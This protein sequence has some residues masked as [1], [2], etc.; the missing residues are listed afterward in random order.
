MRFTTSHGYKVDPLLPPGLGY[1][2][3]RTGIALAKLD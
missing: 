3:P 2:S 1:R